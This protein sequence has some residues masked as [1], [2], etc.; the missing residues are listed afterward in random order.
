MSSTAGLQALVVGPYRWNA[1]TYSSFLRDVY[2]NVIKAE[3]ERLQNFEVEKRKQAELTNSGKIKTETCAKNQSSTNLKEN[4][5]MEIANL[6]QRLVDESGKVLKKENW[7]DIIGTDLWNVLKLDEHGKDR[8]KLDNETDEVAALKKKS[9]VQLLKF[10]RNKISH[11]RTC[12]D[13]VK[14]RLSQFFDKEDKGAYKFNENNF[15]ALWISKFPRLVPYL[16]I[17]LYKFKDTLANYY[18]DYEIDVEKLKD[19]LLDLNKFR[20]VLTDALFADMENGK[21]GT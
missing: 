15:I 10:I 14:E 19:I 13:E 6:V 5:D 3:V 18:P 21:C 16:W 8:Y 7:T 2:D 9:V 20:E 17:K 4:Y 12:K 11:I 1:A